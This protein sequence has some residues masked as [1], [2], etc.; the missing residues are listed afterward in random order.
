MSTRCVYVLYMVLRRGRNYFSMCHY[1]T[2][3]HKGEDVTYKAILIHIYIMH[4]FKVLI[5]RKSS[6]CQDSTAMCLIKLSESRIN[7]LLNSINWLV[8]VREACLCVTCVNVCMSPVW[9]FLCYLCECLYVTCVNVCHLCECFY[10]TCV[11]VCVLPVWMFVCYLCECLYVTCV[12]VCMLPV[13]MYTNFWAD[14]LSQL[15]I[16][17]I[18]SQFCLLVSVI[19]YIWQTYRWSTNSVC[20][21]SVRHNLKVSHHEFL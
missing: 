10:V 6:S 20:L 18:Y 19:L 9:M 11:N 7:T 15:L 1:L 14:F 4:C 21:T 5:F 13:W 3:L 12:N 8:F 2:G 17:Y 16:I